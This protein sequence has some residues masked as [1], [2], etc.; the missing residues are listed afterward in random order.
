MARL[1]RL[2]PHR[3]SWHELWRLQPGALFPILATCKLLRLPYP[4]AYGA[5]PDPL[6]VLP[7][8]EVP[9]PFRSLLD[10]LVAP[11]ESGG[12]VVRF[13]FALPPTPVTEGFGVALSNEAGTI[14]ASSQAVRHRASARMMSGLSLST[15]T[16]QGR[17]IGTTSN[18]R[19][20]DHPPDEEVE[21]YRGMAPLELLACHQARLPSPLECARLS[22]EELPAVFVGYARRW[23]SFHATRGVYVELAPS[24][25]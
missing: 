25:A 11:L 23:I 3:L 17:R 4:R 8:G 18:P 19:T 9:A 2:V 21:Y 6:E 7:S 14:L 10:T 12:F 1:Y 22:P 24:T 13:A 15:K 5:I 16:Q 20:L